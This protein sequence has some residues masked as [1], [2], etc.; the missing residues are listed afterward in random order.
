MVFFKARRPFEFIDIAPRTLCMDH[1]LIATRWRSPCI[2]PAGLIYV[3]TYGAVFNS[4]DVFA[5]IKAL[6]PN[7]LIVD[8]RCLCPPEFD[9]SIPPFVDAILYSTGYAKYVDINFGGFGII[10]NSIPYHRS[11]SAFN[12]EDLTK[13]S[14]NYKHSID[15]FTKFTYSDCEWLDTRHP[16][17]SWQT[18]INEVS[19]ELSRSSEH[20]KEI[21]DIYASL[22]PID[23][24]FPHAFQ[25]WRFNIQ[26][27]EKEPLLKLIFKE[28]FFASGHYKSLVNLFCPGIAPFA[29]EV[30]NHVINLFNDRYITLNQ[31][32]ELTDLLNQSNLLIPGPLS[33]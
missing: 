12:S 2:K 21:N 24:Q 6:S 15:N 10:R 14:I 13:L 20:K 1:D 3:R 9:D 18:Y 16:I 23:I 30:Y 32:R 33:I 19:H 17:K 31:A 25:S 26:V 29:R 5:S 22:L 28:G 4:T 27:R 11:E 7:A 8:D